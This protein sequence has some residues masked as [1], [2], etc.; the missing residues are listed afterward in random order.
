M[1][2]E[3]FVPWRRTQNTIWKQKLLI[4][5]SNSVLCDGPM[6]INY[7]KSLVCSKFIHENRMPTSQFTINCFLA[8]ISK[9]MTWLNFSLSLPSIEEAWKLP[10]PAELTTRTVRLVQQVDTRCVFITE[11]LFPN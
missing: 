5:I 10:I 1:K 4:F 6:I 2:Y 8:V 11:S 3:M 9:L 7:C